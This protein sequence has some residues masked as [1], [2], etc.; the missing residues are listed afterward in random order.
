MAVPRFRNLLNTT[1]SM[2]PEGAEAAGFVPCPAAV[3]HALSADQRQFVAEVYRLAQERVQQQSRQ[4]ASSL[5]SFSA[6]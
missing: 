3:Y 6:N 1:A 2:P 5:P 4:H